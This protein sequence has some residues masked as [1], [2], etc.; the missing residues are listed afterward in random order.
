MRN[1]SMAKAPFVSA[2][3]MAALLALT[4]TPAAADYYQY[5]YTGNPF[6][7][8]TQTVF[9][10]EGDPRGGR[11]FALMAI[12]AVII[13]DHLL[14]GTVTTAD[15]R[16]IRLTLR[17]L[18]NEGETTWLTIPAPP[19]EV[20]PVCPDYGPAI[21]GSLHISGFNE[22]NQPYQWDISISYFMGSP[23]GRAD[24]LTLRT[25]QDSMF[26]DQVDAVDGGYDGAF[27]RRGALTNS[28]GVWAMAVMV[29]EPSTYAL[30]LGGVGLLAG[31]ARR[32]AVMAAKAA[33][34]G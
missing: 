33:A 2:L 6:T 31:W 3:G 14:T 8:T 5:S 29:P 13:A 27:S 1:G 4:P 20:C 17:S 30:M 16:S 34:A 23:T 19:Y 9:P 21:G 11:T 12:D 18:S 24:R 26:G 15:V 7:V 10:W 32:R 28:A 22:L 25:F